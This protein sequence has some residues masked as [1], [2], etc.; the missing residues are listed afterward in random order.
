MPRQRSLFGAIRDVIREEVE[1]AIRSLLAPAPRV[2]RP[3][4]PRAV[5]RQPSAGRPP[6]ATTETHKRRRRRRRMAQ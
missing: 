6:S 5:G 1:S 4:G 2:G 3:P